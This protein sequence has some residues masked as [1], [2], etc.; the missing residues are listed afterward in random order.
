MWSDKE[1][2][3]DC[4]GYSSYVDVL[5][6][7]CIQQD[8]APLTLGIFG[9]W[10]SGKTSLMSMLKNHLDQKTDN[11]IRTLWF[12]AW[13][14]EGRDEAQSA[15]IHAI[16]S[17]LTDG[18]SL[19]GDA[20]V[21]FDRLVKG[22]SVLKLA[23]F[24]TKTAVTLTPDLT[25]FLECFQDQSK[26]VAET[27]EQFERDFEALL[28]KVDVS[29]IVVLIDDLDRCASNKVIET[30]ETIK[31]FLNTPRCTFV[32]GAD[33][34]RIEQAV[35]EVYGVSDSRRTKDYLEKIVQL[36]FNIPIQNPQDI[37]CYV[38]ML[39]VGRYIHSNDGWN[40]FISQRP[41]IYQACTKLNE[42]LLEWVKNNGAH[43]G[44]NSTEIEKEL[45]GILPYVAILGDGLRGNPRQIKRFLNI[46]S[47][48]RKL[49][50]VN[51]LE[52]NDAYL[53]KM[54]VLEYVWE[55]FFNALVET[56]DP[57]TGQS[58]LLEELMAVGATTT[59]E[60]S[61]IVEGFAEKQHLITYLKN[62]PQISGDTDLRPYLFLAQTSINR[63]K[64]AQLLPPDEKALTFAQS[65]AGK[66]RV[67][68]K[69][70]A[71]RAAA[72]EGGTAESIVRHLM[73]KLPECSDNQTRIHIIT[74]LD[75][76]CSKHKRLYVDAVKGIEHMA[77]GGDGAVAVGIAGGNLLANA[78]KAGAAISS[79]AKERFAKAAG[80][81]SVLTSGKNSRNQKR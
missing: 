19:G 22:A 79:I 56:V 48:R 1:T 54:T 12:N 31:L 60:K 18:R 32:I 69:A 34:Q 68:S 23:K 7:I 81:L 39:I 10:G 8:L 50:E 30:F 13:K 26:E 14:Y 27:I 29:H 57:A 53:I 45:G 62:D 3:Y 65:I 72:Q 28:Q 59:K 9:A 46:L 55:D 61:E 80:L 17:K 76:I 16:L 38:G 5:A 67:M 21:V 47:L 58:P 2:L 51:G 40:T 77:P 41:A 71:L 63:G 42:T 20:K 64:Q 36:P 11:K 6:D 24:I 35:S 52:I 70:A 4:L 44:E 15:L 66:D 37:A 33:P 75:T 74:G 25:G 73:A 49:S 78:E 43:L